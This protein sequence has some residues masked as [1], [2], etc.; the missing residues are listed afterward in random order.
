M[1]LARGFPQ[2]WRSTSLTGAAISCSDNDMPMGNPAAIESVDLSQSRRFCMVS[3]GMSVVPE[4]SQ[5][6][7]EF[8]LLATW[9][10]G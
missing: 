1:P 9:V 6:V 4:F 3:L 8:I 5:L 7:F 2:R 10:A